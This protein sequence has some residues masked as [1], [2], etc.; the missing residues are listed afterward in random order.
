M[1]APLGTAARN[2]ASVATQGSTS[3][4]GKSKTAY[5]RCN[6]LW[7]YHYPSYT[8]S[9]RR[10]CQDRNCFKI[11]PGFNDNAFNLLHVI[12]CYRLFLLNS[13]WILT[14]ASKLWTSHHTYCGP[15]IPSQAAVSVHKSTSTVGFPRES[16]ISRAFT[17]WIV[18]FPPP[19]W[20]KTSGHW[21]AW[22]VYV[23]NY[24]YSKIVVCLCC[25][26]WYDM[27]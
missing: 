11:A 25:M 22:N 21:K 2:N 19:G 3:F 16:K 20:W 26:W 17:A 6:F 13:C 14:F 4:N 7:S 8:G 1:D 27:S 15:P 18:L 23:Y 9:F 5:S 24:V 12:D 10:L